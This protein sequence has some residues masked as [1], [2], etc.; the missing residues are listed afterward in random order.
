MLPGTPRVKEGHTVA[1]VRRAVLTVLGLVAA[2]A[3]S[4]MLMLRHRLARAFAGKD[5]IDFANRVERFE[6]I[7]KRA[8]LGLAAGGLVMVIV[9]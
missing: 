9:T 1:D 2:G 7:I 8:G 4:I 6:S 3:G 5:S